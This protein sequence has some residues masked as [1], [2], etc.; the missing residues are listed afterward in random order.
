MP[1]QGKTTREECLNIAITSTSRL[2]TTRMESGQPPCL[3]VDVINVHAPLPPGTLAKRGETIDEL[4]DRLTPQGRQEFGTQARSDET[5]D[6]TCKESEEPTRFAVGVTNLQA[7]PPP[8]ASAKRGE[9][10][11]ELIDQLQPH[12]KQEYGTQAGKN[13]TIDGLIGRLTTS[14]G[15]HKRSWVLAQKAKHLQP[16]PRHATILTEVCTA[17]D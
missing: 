12:G 2:A 3:D 9:T 1:R 8:G 17:Q 16:D 6:T 4:I 5:I 10:I 7:P 15:L 11:D 14:E 13:E